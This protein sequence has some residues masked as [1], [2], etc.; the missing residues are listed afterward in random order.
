M[1]HR[2]LN[3]HDL[4]DDCPSQAMFFHVS[5]ASILLL[6]KGLLK[7]ANQRRTF[8][9]RLLHNKSQVVE[10]SQ[11][12][13]QLVAVTIMNSLFGSLVDPYQS[14]ALQRPIPVIRQTIQFHLW[15][16]TIGKVP[17]IVRKPL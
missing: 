14:S 12:P 9:L 11:Q 13:N 6:K 2:P 7:L 16:N 4:S 10:R 5:I 1:A 8:F 15:L 17:W 3:D